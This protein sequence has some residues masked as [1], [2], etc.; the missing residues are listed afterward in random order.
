MLILCTQVCIFE[1]S[2]VLKRIGQKNAVLRCIPYRTGRVLGG[3]CKR[4]LYACA[5]GGGRVEELK[6]CVGRL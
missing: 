6:E 3:G 4:R 1:G 2:N 5:V